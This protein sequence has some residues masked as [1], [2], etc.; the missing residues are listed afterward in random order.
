MVTFFL[1]HFQREMPSVINY[2][3]DLTKMD[4]TN[5]G[6]NEEDPEVT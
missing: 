3:F 5:E 1:F 4:A 6:A 2:D